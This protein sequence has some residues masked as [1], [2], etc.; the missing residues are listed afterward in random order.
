MNPESI[1]SPAAPAV[2]VAILSDFGFQD[3][4][5]GVMKCVMLARNPNLRF[6]DLCHECGRGNITEAAYLLF[7]A[8]QFL[9][10]SALVLCVV[11]PSVGSDRRELVATGNG[12]TY[13]GPDNGTIS[14]ISR[15]GLVDRFYRAGGDQAE[16]D[17]EARHFTVGISS[18][19]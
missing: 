17:P 11:D 16:S 8:W 4:Y 7:S 1:S 12:R 9:L 15:F 18:H 13:V 5:V 2:D 14:L 6:I 19:P 3:T 10:A